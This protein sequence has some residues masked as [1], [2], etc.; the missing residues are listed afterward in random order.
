M[1]LLE[2]YESGVIARNR[3]PSAILSLAL[4]GIMSCGEVIGHS[5]SLDTDYYMSIDI[6]DYDAY[7]N[8]GAPKAMYSLSFEGDKFLLWISK[9]V[10]RKGVDTPDY[11]EGIL[12]SGTLPMS[13][14]R[15]SSVDLDALAATSSGKNYCVDM[16]AVKGP[17]ESFT[18]S[19][20]CWDEGDEPADLSTIMEYLDAAYDHGVL[21]ESS[22]G[23]AVSVPEERPSD[24]IRQ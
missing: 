17:E 21:M 11:Y 18:D 8:R 12:M 6:Y 24:H 2:R 14:D 4:L 23:T 19:S 22:D 9:T 1:N 15:L 10:R 7:M 16:H 5:D 20:F 3:L 13:L